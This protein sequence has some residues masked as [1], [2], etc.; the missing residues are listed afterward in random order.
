MTLFFA[1]TN[2]F[3]PF[4]ALAQTMIV[5]ATPLYGEADHET[6]VVEYIRCAERNKGT[7]QIVGD[8]DGA[9]QVS[10]QRSGQN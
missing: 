2:C 8:R 3:F 5:R 4:A 9:I 6:L 1:S 10:F 7:L